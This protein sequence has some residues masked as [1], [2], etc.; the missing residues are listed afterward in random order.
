MESSSISGERNPHGKTEKK[1]HGMPLT[2]GVLSGA[3]FALGHNVSL[4]TTTF[5][6]LLLLKARTGSVNRNFICIQ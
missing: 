6:R 5:H 1:E 2:Q 3:E 4:A